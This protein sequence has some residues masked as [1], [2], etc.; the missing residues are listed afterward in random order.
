MAD[1]EDMPLGL[2]LSM[3][4]NAKARDHFANLS[5]AE[6]ENVEECARN[7]NSKAEM[8]RIIDRLAEGDS[9]F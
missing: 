2:S 4:M 8:E 1:T 5:K 3:A 7:V 9:C 6:R